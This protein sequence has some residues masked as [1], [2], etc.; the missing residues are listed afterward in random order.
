MRILKV[1]M[2]GADLNW[3]NPTEVLGKKL[4]FVIRD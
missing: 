2:Y 1:L 4:I 3:S